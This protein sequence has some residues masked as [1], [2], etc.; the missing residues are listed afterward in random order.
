[1]ALK[2]RLKTWD[3]VHVASALE[4]SADV[5]FT[6]DDGLLPLDVAVEQLKIEEPYIFG[7]PT[8]FDDQEI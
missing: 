3:A 8:L 1:L 5:L 4:V 7:A 2:H 6:T